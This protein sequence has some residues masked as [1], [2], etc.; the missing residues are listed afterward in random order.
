[1]TLFRA[2][3]ESSHPFS[4]RP[5]ADAPRLRWK[6]FPSI[7]IRRESMMFAPTDDP[8]NELP[9]TTMSLANMTCRP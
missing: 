5:T 9:R 3:I 4:V 1:M 6:R 7:R 8:P 2:T